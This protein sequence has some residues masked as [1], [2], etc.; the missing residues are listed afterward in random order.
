MVVMVWV[1]LEARGAAGVGVFVRR[2]WRLLVLLIVVP[3]LVLPILRGVSPPSD[4]TGSA[5]ASGR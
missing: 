5:S 4:S 3:L 1:E 2:R